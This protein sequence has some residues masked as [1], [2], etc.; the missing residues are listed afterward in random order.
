VELCALS[1]LP[2]E[3]AIYGCTYQGTL[4]ERK[5]H[6]DCNAA[7][8]LQV[9]VEHIRV[10]EKERDDQMS[11]VRD[12]LKMAVDNIK[13]LQKEVEAKKKELYMQKGVNRVLWEQYCRRVR[14]SVT[15]DDEM[16]D[17]YGEGEGEGEDIGPQ[18]PWE[19]GAGVK[20]WDDDIS[21]V[22]DITSTTSAGRSASTSTL[23]FGKVYPRKK[24]GILYPRKKET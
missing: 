5:H 7:H 19:H 8:H 17:V 9:A 18:P 13:A 11:T 20:P 15:E 24:D 4:E 21:V 6:N 3:Y 1:V 12:H 14:A 23:N 16:D 2:C 22:S 10:L